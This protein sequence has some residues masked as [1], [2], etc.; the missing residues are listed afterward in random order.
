M[1]QS[2]YP[3][4]RF[5]DAHAAI[6]W[7]EATLGAERKEVHEDEGVVHHAELRVA[8]DVLMLGSYRE[9]GPGHRPGQSTTYVA[10]D[11]VDAYWDRAREAGAEVV[12]E[13]AEMDYGSREFSLRDPEG[14]GW[15]VGTYRPQ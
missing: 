9:D 5:H 15:S 7:L 2:L 14:N 3:T 11:D 1:S 6:A 4:F 13:L 8:G 12:R 10:V